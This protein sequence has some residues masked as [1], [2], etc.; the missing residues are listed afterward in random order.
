MFIL[1]D[2]VIATVL[3]A[4]VVA[5]AFLI[6]SYIY[7]MVS[8]IPINPKYK[9]GF[10]LA[11]ASVLV[12]VMYVLINPIS[13]LAAS[14]FCYLFPALF[15]VL[16]EKEKKV[17][18]C[19]VAFLSS[20][21]KRIICFFPMLLISIIVST[22]IPGFT[23]EKHPIINQFVLLLIHVLTFFLT[24][25]L[26]KIKRFKKGFQFFQEE[27]NLGIGLVLSGAL[28]IY[29]V[30]T[31]S[32]QVK[33]Y[34]V[35]MIGLVGF[36]ISAFGIYVWIR[37]SITAHYREKMKLRSEEY[38][39]QTLAETEQTL[40]KMQQSN[41]FLAKLVH[42]DNHLISALNTS[43]DDYFN[44]DD[45]S[46]KDDLLRDIQTLAK[47]RTELID[48]EQREAKILPSTGNLLI[49]SSINDLYFKAVA[50]GIDFDIDV[51]APV[52]EIIG[53]YLSQTELQTLLC[54]HIKDA[55][56]AVDAKGEG[57]GKILVSLSVKDNNYDITIFD[58]GV[59]FEIDTLSKLGKERVTTHAEDGGSGI[60][61]M[62]TFETLKK[63]YASLIITENENKIPFSKSISIR[64]DGLSAFVIQTYRAEKLKS[65]IKRED[66]TI[67]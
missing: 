33:V 62:T 24:F 63:S 19:I 15:F 34:L 8:V 57:S 14:L 2:Q 20:T 56:I 31:N 3:E 18:K 4:G 47:E 37:Q 17:L 16:F 1:P 52:D 58:S 50:H 7:L 25:L 65:A 26:F 43:I 13:K 39:K 49:D 60:G 28:F 55:I 5:V 45:K 41:E 40:E 54:D 29:F 48:K 22:F 36:L 35:A 23:P 67:V 53:K 61:F 12:A 64:F 27:K 32:Y 10:V 46:F 6:S 9:N 30:I 59:D 51:S 38:N 44:S 42:R 21:L 66:I 11:A